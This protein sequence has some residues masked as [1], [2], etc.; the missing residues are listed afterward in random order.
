VVGQPIREAF[1][2]GP[3]LARLIE[4]LE[5]VL[6]SARPQWDVEA[7]EA[8]LRSIMQTVP[9]AMIWVEDRPGGGTIFRFSLRAATIEEAADAG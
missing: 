7:A 3:A 8:R 4:A 9:D 1:P 6:R 2:A 5:R